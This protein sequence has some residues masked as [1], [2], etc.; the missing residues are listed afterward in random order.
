ML[1]VNIPTDIST[2]WPDGKTLC[3]FTSQ[4]KK[5]KKSYDPQLEIDALGSSLSM[6]QSLLMYTLLY[7]TSPQKKLYAWSLRPYYVF[8]LFQLISLSWLFILLLE[9]SIIGYSSALNSLVAIIETLA[10]ISYYSIN[11][12]FFFNFLFLFSL[13]LS[14]WFNLYSLMSQLYTSAILLFIYTYLLSWIYKNYYFSPILWIIHCITFII[15][16][17]FLYYYYIYFYFYS[18]IYFISPY[19]MV[20]SILFVINFLCHKKNK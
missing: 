11:F 5:K 18:Y 1:L 13:T 10:S 8:L 7:T 20:I 9:I 17:K 12:Y 16:F 14:L 15:N 4:I 19:L 2:L 3:T 6:N